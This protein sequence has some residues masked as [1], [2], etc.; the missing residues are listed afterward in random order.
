MF[1]FS[2]L[3]VLT[4]TDNA[5]VELLKR[6][7]I[8]VCISMIFYDYNMMLKVLSLSTLNSSFKKTLVTSLYTDVLV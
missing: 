2:T 1:R 5:L 7:K 8:Q 6:T 3:G 4:A